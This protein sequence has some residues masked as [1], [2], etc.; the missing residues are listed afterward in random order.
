[1]SAVE[2]KRKVPPRADVSVHRI[3]AVTLCAAER[4]RLRSLPVERLLAAFAVASCRSTYKR[5]L[6]WIAGGP[7]YEFRPKAFSSTDVLAK[8]GMDAGLRR[9]NA[10]NKEMSRVPMQSERGSSRP[11]SLRAASPVPAI[12]P[13]RLRDRLAPSRAPRRVRQRQSDRA[14]KAPGRRACPAIRQSPSPELR[15]GQEAS[16][17]NAAD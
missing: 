6:G 1:M 5:E 3:I 16:S 14:H 17:A 15:S 7:I 11:R 9:E 4:R 10:T 8:A 2:A 12:P 13:R